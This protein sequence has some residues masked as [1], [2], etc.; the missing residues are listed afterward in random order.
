MRRGIS[1]A[2][3]GL[4]QVSEAGKGFR[5]VQD[6]IQARALYQHGSSQSHPR[7]SQS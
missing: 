2:V 7:L 5:R 1:K 6:S 3:G 4:W